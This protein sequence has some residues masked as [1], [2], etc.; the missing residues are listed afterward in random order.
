MNKTNSDKYKVLLRHP[1]FIFCTSLALLVAAIPSEAASIRIDPAAITAKVGETVCFDV[2]VD[3]IPDSGLGTFQFTLVADDSTIGAAPT[4]AEALDDRVTVISPLNKGGITSTTS[5]LGS[6]FLSGTGDNGVLE[7]ENTPFSGGEGTYTFGHTYGGKPPSGSGSIARFCLIVGNSATSD[8]VINLS[9]EDVKLL[10]GDEVYELD[11]IVGSR[12]TIPCAATVPDVVDM[13][14]QEAEDAIAGAGLIIDTVTEEHSDIMTAGHIVSQSLS[15]GERADCNAS[16]DLVVSLGPSNTAPSLNPI[17]NKVIDTEQQLTFTVSAVDPEND[18]L[19]YGIE[20]CPTGAAFDSQTG[21]FDWTPGY[22]Q[23]GTF[24]VI[25]T[26]SDGTLSDSA[27]ITITVNKVNH[28]PVA[29]AGGPYTAAEGTSVTIDAGGSID[30]DGDTLTYSW[31]LDNDGEFD[32]AEGVTTRYTWPD[33]GVYRVAVKVSDGKESD[34]SETEVTITNVAPTA[35]AAADTT[36]LDEGGSVTFSGSATD[37]GNIDVLTYAWSFGDGAVS[38]DRNPAHAYSDNGTYTASLVVTD[39]D[40]GT[41]SAA[42]ITI[43]VRNIAPTITSAPGAGATEELTYAYRVLASDVAAD[44]LTYSLVT[45]PEGMTI[46]PAGGLVNWTPTNEQAATSHSVKIKVSDDDGGTAEQTFAVNVI[47]VNDSPVAAAGEDRTA[48][49]GSA[50]SFDAAGSTDD[51][52]LNPSGEVLAYYW[53]FGDESTAQGPTAS[54][55]YADNGTYTATLTVTDKAGATSTDTLVVTVNNVAPGVTLVGPKGGEIWKDIQTINWEASDPGI[56]DVLSFTIETKVG[57]EAWK[58]I[59]QV[60]D[61]RAYT[62]DTFT[63]NDNAYL[64]RITASD[65]LDTSEDRTAATFVVDNTPPQTSHDYTLHD[66]WTN[67]DVTITLTGTDATSG[68]A[69]TIYQ[70]E[71]AQPFNGA[72]S[73]L[74]TITTEGITTITFYSIDR[75]GNKEAPRTVVVKLDKTPPVVTITPE[76]EPDYGE[77]YNKDIAITFKAVDE[78]SGLTDPGDTRTVPVTDEGSKV[79]ISETFTDMAGNATTASIAI[80]LDKTPPLTTHNYADDGMW[81]NTIPVEIVLNAEDNL[82]GVESTTYQAE[83]GVNFGPHTEQTTPIELPSIGAEAEGV[84]VVTFYSQ[85][86]AGNIE[87]AQEITILLDLTPPDIFSVKIEKYDPDKEKER[88]LND[89]ES[90]HTRDEADAEMVRA[91]AFLHNEVPSAEGT[92]MYNDLSEGE[93]AD[94]REHFGQGYTA[95]WMN[96]YDK[97]FE[98]FRETYDEEVTEHK[99]KPLGHVDILD[100]VRVTWTALDSNGIDRTFVEIN[101]IRVEGTLNEATPNPT[102]Y[103]AVIDFKEL[104]GMLSPQSAPVTTRAY[105]PANNE[106]LFT[107]TLALQPFHV[108]MEATANNMKEVVAGQE[109]EVLLELNADKQTPLRV[110]DLA[111]VQI[112]D[113][114][115]ILVPVWFTHKALK[116]HREL[117]AYG[118]QIDWASHLV[119]A[120]GCFVLAPII[121]PIPASD[122]KEKSFTIRLLSLQP[123]SGDTVVGRIEVK[124]NREKVTFHYAKDKKKEKK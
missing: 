113:E 19:T 84:T 45:A 96:D 108:L 55:T 43:T 15:P 46:Q 52:L 17:G 11:H 76:R 69:T 111:Q 122:A 40:G 4:T 77:W 48:D 41:S 29:D 10:R 103:M 25:F 90:A 83:G 16:I 34:F 56:H 67:N 102:D 7:M 24:Q 86:Q 30:D 120:E 74:P 54:H 115:P 105:D 109:R 68:V 64:L 3:D 110:G 38:N 57:T 123:I 58:E 93:Q 87:I 39:N 37:P 100:T 88:T 26:V 44:I 75:A 28:A 23:A 50:V 14:G 98:E 21:V 124:D 53:T 31:D 2:I 114:E 107:G 20:N 35:A 36:T 91:L 61:V 8:R 33:N 51:D 63:V 70:A 89:G 27:A 121:L 118:D 78:L 82:S 60:G 32:D 97:A 81:V 12:V 47:N 79:P 95:Y 1:F 112:D 71:G 116:G 99:E 119:D 104:F 117:G 22:E 62:W 85:D 92:F 59:A 101:G 72:G 13:T 66:Q 18:V 80:S 65:G 9:I 94:C 5:G 106:A 73:V 6:F 42:R 49:E